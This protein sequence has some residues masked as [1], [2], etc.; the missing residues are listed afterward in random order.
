[1]KRILVL[2]FTLAVLLTGCSAGGIGGHSAKPSAVDENAFNTGVGQ[3]VCAVLLS[4]NPQIKIFLDDARNVTAIQCV[5]EDA[6][7][8]FGGEYV[9]MG[10]SF[11]DVVENALNTLHNAG[12]LTN[13]SDL[14]F[15]VSAPDPTAFDDV[16]AAAKATATAFCQDKQLVLN[17]SYNSE[18]AIEILPEGVQPVVI[19]GDTIDY[20]RS[21]SG[22]VI[23]LLNRV[24]DGKI[25]THYDEKGFPTFEIYYTDS[26]ETIFR[27]FD[28]GNPT[29]VREYETES[30]AQITYDENGRPLSIVCSNG[31]ARFENGILVDEDMTYP[32]GRHR[33][34]SYDAAGRPVHT[35]QIMPNGLRVEETFT[36]YDNGKHKQIIS[37]IDGQTSVRNYAEDGRSSTAVHGSGAVD[38]E[39]YRANGSLEKQIVD[40]SN[41]NPRGNVLY[42]EYT[43]APGHVPLTGYQR[44]DDGEEFYLT[45]HGSFDVVTLEIHRGSEVTI[46]YWIGNTIIGG[47]ASSGSAWG[48][49]FA[50]YSGPIEGGSIGV[51]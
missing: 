3:S 41:A 24:S 35:V 17:V 43:Y 13:G 45:Y 8:L 49:T 10:K 29:P 18:V 37:N 48:D 6:K 47:I 7:T 23:W 5:N 16:N 21:E 2:F 51:G 25:E 11:D 39:Y 34:A 22:R 44:R 42:Q 38:T 50:T 46:E 36:Y 40:Y 19:N 1:M 20:K 15:R 14:H 30:T 9:S 32:D 4:V 27:W 12:Y 28:P 26:G 33:T 31:T